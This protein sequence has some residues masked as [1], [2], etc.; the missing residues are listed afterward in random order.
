ME[1]DCTNHINILGHGC[2][3]H[4]L[5]SNKKLSIPGGDAV[6]LVYPADA[7]CAYF[8]TKHVTADFPDEMM[9]YH[10]RMDRAALKD[11]FG[12]H[13]KQT[14]GLGDRLSCIEEKKLWKETLK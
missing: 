9:K 5:K 4:T 2:H 7:L 10:R 13:G 12:E 14:P 6:F 3:T 8:R 1:V 11:H